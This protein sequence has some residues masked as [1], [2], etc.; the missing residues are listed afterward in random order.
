MSIEKGPW[1]VIHEEDE[2][3]HYFFVNTPRES[4]V[5]KCYNPD[6]ANFIASAP[7]MYEALRR[8]LTFIENGIEY[9][10]IKMPDVDSGD[11][12]LETP[13]IISKALAKARGYEIE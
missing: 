13:S 11:P 3:L 9:G 4:T 10:Y 1:N 2:G 5:A 12:A 8:A 6:T 7:D